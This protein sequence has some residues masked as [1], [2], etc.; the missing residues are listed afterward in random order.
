MALEPFQRLWSLTC[1]KCYSQRCRLLPQLHVSSAC[2]ERRLSKGASGL[3]LSAM[4]GCCKS[5]SRAG[6]GEAEWWRVE[7]MVKSLLAP[8]DGGGFLGNRRAVL[9]GAST[10]QGP[11]TGWSPPKPLLPASS[12]SSRPL[13]HLV[14]S[15]ALGLTAQSSVPFWTARVEG[16]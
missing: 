1:L 14:S 11:I 3:T 12:I 2:S 8:G 15:L 9:L 4:S 10:R 5:R 13:L 7:E 6:D 16:L